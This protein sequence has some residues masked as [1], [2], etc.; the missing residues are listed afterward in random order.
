MSDYLGYE[1][2]KNDWLAHYGTKTHSGRYPW[3]SGENPYQRL[4]RGSIRARIK[5]LED[6]NPGWTRTDIAH[7]LGMSSGELRQR[8]TAEVDEETRYKE[9]QIIQ[10]HE[11]GYS[12]VEIGKMLGVSEGKIRY[13]LKNG[14]KIKKNS[15]RTISDQLESEV[16]KK[17]FIDVGADS[18]LAL[19]CTKTKMDAAVSLLK[20]EGYEV[21]T[22]W[23]DQLGTNHKTTMKI[24]CEPGTEKSYLYD[25][26]D[27]IHELDESRMIKADGSVQLGAVKPKSVSRDRIMVR[28]GD[29]G[30]AEKDGTIELRRGVDDISL[31]AAN[32]AQVR[33]AV[34]DKMYMKGMAF[35]SDDMPPG[36]DIIYN[37]NK[38]KGSEDY[39]KVFK[40]LDL[41]SDNPFGATIKGLYDKERA[42]EDR[43]LKL[44]QREYVDKDGKTQQSCINVVNEEGTWGEWSK[45]LSS[46]FLSKQSVP[47]AK[48][49]LDL[50]YKQS[51]SDL[52]DILNLTEP[53]VKKKLLEDFAD[54]CDAAAVELKAASLPRQRTHVI[55]PLT[56][57]K[58]NE[59]YAP[60]YNTGEHVC[61][62]RFPHAGIFEIPELVV[63][64]NQKEGKNVL[65]QAPDAVGISIKTAQKL[66]GADFDGD[67]V[68][69][70]PSDN[71][72]IKTKPT[73]EGLKDFDPQQ[74]RYQ[75][76]DSAPKMTDRQKGLEMGSV[77]N[78][79][80]DMTLIGCSDDEMVRAVKHSMVVIDAYKHH[81][82]YKLSEKDNNIAE[83]KKKYQGKANAGAA[84]IVS[85]ASGQAHIDEV[86]SYAK[87]DPITGEKIYEPTGKTHTKWA[88]EQKTVVDP[89]TGKKTKVD[90]LGEDG[91]PIW[92]NK[93]EEKNKTKTTK[94]AATNDAYTL[95]SDGKGG[96]PMEE[97]YARYANDM[98]A[99]GNRARREAL[100]IKSRPY[101]ESAAKTYAK[102]VESL[103]EKYLLA[104]KNAPR[105]RQAQMIANSRVRAELATHPEWKDDKDRIKKINNQ[106]LASG[107]AT[108]GAKKDRVTFTDREWEA[109]QSGAIR[110]TKLKKLINEA[111]KDEVVRRSMPKEA[112]KISATKI[113]AMK[114]M[115][116]QGFTQQEIANSLGVSVSSV[117]KALMGR[118]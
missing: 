8:V 87:I 67:T 24:L 1:R 66:S 61:L 54:G 96:Y 19:N 92:I 27:E 74:P 89:V 14:A 3:G 4:D 94:M 115:A 70:I 88:K 7:H 25:H 72:K 90:V 111:N 42:P 109:I 118:K 57:I 50:S 79:I 80:T 108:A 10:L 101:S 69:V 45:S 31:G 117:N 83:L 18:E 28:Y 104:R 43:E 116:N 113:A 105:E 53:T 58:D 55:L 6:A 81:L 56:T 86:K 41:N 107:R 47:L 110:P 11:K 112:T 65:G 62:V 82:D 68:L 59:I 5:E 71:V 21:H 17:R 37:S 34:D 60:N 12:N 44:T 85:R 63:N 36:V 9:Q 32:Y 77:S 48:R 26:L 16:K 103:E 106:A 29:E 102:E 97:V 98:K 2:A 49:Q 84:T 38:P 40:K 73:L 100:A 75:L 13:S 35:Y 78:L 15:L 23:V 51:L 91:K 76:P 39:G 46:Q 93:G 22:I 99:L 64:N 95:T 30:G 20:D 33:I 52:D 114:A